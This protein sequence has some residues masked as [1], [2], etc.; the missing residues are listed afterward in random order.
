M[1]C[2]L[3]EMMIALRFAELDDVAAQLTP[4][5]ASIRALADSQPDKWAEQLA[6]IATLWEYQGR[7]PTEF[8]AFVAG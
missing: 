7:L 1:M 8:A 2:D 6:Q 4:S 5:N 3:L